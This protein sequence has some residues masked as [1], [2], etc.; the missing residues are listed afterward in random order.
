MVSESGLIEEAIVIEEKNLIEGLDADLENSRPVS[1][2]DY[3]TIY[4]PV[5]TAIS[6]L[7]SFFNSIRVT[8]TFL[9]VRITVP[10]E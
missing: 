9:P 7:F 6:T 10:V 8:A 5:P 4:V 3:P 2:V 1:D